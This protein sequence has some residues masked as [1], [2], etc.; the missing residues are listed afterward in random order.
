MRRKSHLYLGH[1]LLNAYLPDIS[2]MQTKAFLL[3]CTEPDMNPT[4]YLKGSLRSQWLRGH[5]YE[6]ASRFLHRLAVRLERK[7]RLNLWDFYS[8]GKLMHYTQDAF[9]AAHNTCFPVDLG[10]HRQYERQLQDWFLN[11]PAPAERSLLPALPAAEI[12]QRN[13]DAYIRHPSDINRDT[14]FAV[15]VCF[16]L[17]A[18]IIGM[19]KVL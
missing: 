6:N 12:I 18:R 11:Q 8:L 4:T 13:H 2:A 9:T 1:A 7:S 17:M 3:G 15:S 10:S 5:N 19:N 14:I 16:L